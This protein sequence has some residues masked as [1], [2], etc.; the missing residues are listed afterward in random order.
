MI[1]WKNQFLFCFLCIRVFICQYLSVFLN[2]VGKAFFSK[3]R[4]VVSEKPGTT[5]DSVDLF[6]E[7]NGKRFRLI[8]TAGIRRKG[9]VKQKIEKFSV[10]KSLK[11][12]DDCDVALILIDGSEGITDQILLLQDMPMTK[13]AAHFF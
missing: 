6:I 12:L 11:S 9:K 7:H 4:L 2:D 1:S 8:D 10:L 13:S 5:R 3:N